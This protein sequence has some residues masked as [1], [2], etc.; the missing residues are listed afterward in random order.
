MPEQNQLTQG[1]LGR[2]VTLRK[3]LHR[4][5]E[6]SGK[7]KRTAQQ[8]QRF[9]SGLHPD[10]IIGPIGGCGL[11]AV[12]NGKK[13]GK[14][15]LLRADLDALP[16]AEDSDDSWASR[17][18]GVSHKCGHDGHMA[19]LAGTA[20]VLA[21]KRPVRGR[22]VLLFQPA[23]ETGAGARRVL[24]DPLFKQI[25][26]DKVFALHNLP[27]FPLG[28]VVL[29]NGVFASASMGMI[30]KLR[31]STSH[32]GQPQQGNSPALALA[33]L[34][35]SYSAAPQHKAGLSEPA[36][37]TVI[38]AKLGEVAFGTSPG[39]ALI[40]ATVRATRNHVM[41]RLFTYC[42]ELAY[43]I[44]NAHGLDVHCHTTD[45]F[46]VTSNDAAMV[47]TVQQA[48]RELGIDIH[49]L[50][51]PFAWSED[52]GHFTA[53]YPGALFGLGAGREHPALHSPGYFF[54]DTLLRPGISLFST[55]TRLAL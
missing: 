13:P 33:Q 51:H 15:V 24:A 9:L 42:K 12:F 14:T 19:I 27:G 54:P 26:P 37:V 20:A 25:L 35:E 5:A 18:P 44:G 7:E 34:I 6:L 3:E 4:L 40:M 41:D 38:H 11:A 17:Q 31:G 1:E 43:G 50:A 55:I 52:F 46:P 29:R 47:Q 39:E 36:K 23:E 10:A 28:S 53:Q 8:V 2:V 49:H 48:A 16:I 22:V 32:A 30:V 45:I 21:G